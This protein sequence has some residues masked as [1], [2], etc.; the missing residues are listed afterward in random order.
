MVSADKSDNWV[1][2]A[3]ES[4]RQMEHSEKIAQIENGPCI[5][6]PLNSRLCEPWF[7][8]HM[9]AFIGRLYCIRVRSLV[10]YIAYVC[11]H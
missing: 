8:L 7:I 9:F 4:R 10:V 3:L 1:S 6:I 2:D 11:I 5:Q